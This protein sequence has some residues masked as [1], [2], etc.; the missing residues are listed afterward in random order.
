MDSSPENSEPW[1]KSLA[2]FL[3]DPTRLNLKRLLQIEAVEDNDLEFKRELIPFDS[4]AKH[5]LAMANKKGGAIVFGVEET[6]PN[7]FASCGLSESFDITDIDK[8]LSAYISKKLE[9]GII[10]VCYKGEDHP[11]FED[12]LFLVIIVKHNPRYIPFISLKSGDNIKKDTIYIRRNRASEPINHDELQEAINDR[13][14]TEYST[15]DERQLIEHLEELKTLYNHIP[16]TIKQVVSY[17]PP[18]IP[19][20]LISGES[21]KMMLG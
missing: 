17:T 14:N 6:K 3:K 12:K 11:E 2:S 4:L 8:K 16:K 15:T 10:P 7:Q 21:I 1:K 19:L 5:M 18:S 13:I 9:A 20:N